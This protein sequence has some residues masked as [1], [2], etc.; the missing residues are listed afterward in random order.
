MITEWEV[1][2]AVVAIAGFIVTVFKASSF[3]NKLESSITTLNA[4]ISVL[5][6][7]VDEIAK[8]NKA[9]HERL[10]DHNDEQDKQLSDH[11]K[12]IGILERLEE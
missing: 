8:S 4:S 7:A 2:L 6:K 10:W 12:R 3:F 11:E 9:S 1:F 5:N